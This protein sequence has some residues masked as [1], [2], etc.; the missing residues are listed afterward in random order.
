MPRYISA[1]RAISAGVAFSSL[2]LAQPPQE[3]SGRGPSAEFVPLREPRLVP[4]GQAKFLKDTD[5]VIGVSENG[6][7]KAYEPDVTAWHTSLRIGWATCGL[8]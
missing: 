6:V 4:A 3:K 1:I 5:R 8:S 2:L 7:A